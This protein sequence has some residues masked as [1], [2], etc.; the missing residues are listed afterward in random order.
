MYK[1]S[2]NQTCISNVVYLD[3][4]QE[5]SSVDRR[6]ILEQQRSVI[7]QNPS[8]RSASI[9]K[10]KPKFHALSISRDTDL[11]HDRFAQLKSLI[12]E[13]ELTVSEISIYDVRTGDKS[14]TI[15]CV[16]PVINSYSFVIENEFDRSE[17]IQMHGMTWKL[18]L[19]NS[20][21]QLIVFGVP[22]MIQSLLIQYTLT[23]NDNIVTDK[24]TYLKVVIAGSGR[25]AIEAMGRVLS[26]NMQQTDTKLVQLKITLWSVYDTNDECIT[27][28]CYW[29][30]DAVEL[31]EFTSYLWELPTYDDKR[32]RC[33]CNGYC[34]IFSNKQYIPTSLIDFV[35]I[36][37]GDWNILNE[38]KN[39]KDKEEFYSDMFIIDGFKYRL[40]I[41]YEDGKYNIGLELM[42]LSPGVS[43]LVVRYNL[44]IKQ[45]VKNDSERV[46]RF[47]QANTMMIYTSD[48]AYDE[49]WFDKKEA[50][51]LQNLSL[52][53]AIMTINVEDKHSKPVRDWN[54]Y[55]SSHTTN[56]PSFVSFKWR[57][58]DKQMI[59]EIRT[60]P[61][62]VGYFSKLFKVFGCKMC[63]ELYPRVCQIC[64]IFKI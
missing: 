22:S 11:N 20:Y 4:R 51:N 14:L 38:I 45:I 30:N 15:P 8:D 62:S 29:K 37:V 21:G 13:L 63:L 57:I 49:Y 58:S 12:I 17:I 31:L 27:D 10:L 59:S 32:L 5:S 55:T 2:N 47:N 52:K 7:Q 48:G 61:P 33:I 42:S 28:E 60:A 6:F 35:R 39:A 23:V 18:E 50:T 44:S 41:G 26:T 36:F 16:A 64:V 34:R 1:I 43:S 53:L 3:Q 25:S 24:F 56:K 9:S 54:K 46:L 19:E 40:K